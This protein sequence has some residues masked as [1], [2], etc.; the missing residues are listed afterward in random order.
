[1]ILYTCIIKQ[2]DNLVE[3]IKEPG[4]Q[5]VCFSDRPFTHPVWEY[6]PIEPLGQ[7]DARRICRRYK[8]LSHH[9]FPGE[10]TIWV[11]GRVSLNVSVSQL[12]AKYDGDLCARPHPS[13]TCIYDEGE[14]VKKQNY[15][16]AQIVDKQLAR[17]RED[18]Y[19]EN[20]GLNETGILLRRA[21]EEVKEFE[22]EWWSLIST[23]SKRDQLSFN[24]VS[25]FQGKE[26]TLMDRGDV[27]VLKHRIPTDLNR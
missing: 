17:F 10:D 4:V 24:Y 23:G 22:M 8:V 2:K 13:R 25:F 12:V 15:E 14:V 1:M 27:R 18:G 21:T 11:D 6:R 9:Y 16:N 3:V 19:P 20:N 7:S 5:Y 26:I